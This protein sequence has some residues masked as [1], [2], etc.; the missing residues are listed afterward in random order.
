MDDNKIDFKYLF[1]ENK[2]LKQQIRNFVNIIE[3][4]G[5]KPIKE[6]TD[7]KITGKD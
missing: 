7:D 5:L 1:E 3:M 2:V 4:F 6:K